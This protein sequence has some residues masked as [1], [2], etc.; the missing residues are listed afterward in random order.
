Q[1]RQLLSQ[2]L[3]EAEEAISEASEQNTGEQ[4]QERYEQCLEAMSAYEGNGSTR[5]FH[6]QRQDREQNGKYESH[7]G[8]RC[9]VHPGFPLKL[10]PSA[11]PRLADRISC[12]PSAP[13]RGST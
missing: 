2:H 8:W 11:S 12:P 7:L 13:F 6:K 9:Q 4:Q 3:L 1:R 10:L 5:V